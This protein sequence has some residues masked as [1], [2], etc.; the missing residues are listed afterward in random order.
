M[1]IVPFSKSPIPGAPTPGRDPPSDAFALM[2]VA[3]M[4]AEGKF[5]QQ[6]PTE[7]PNGPSSSRRIPN[8]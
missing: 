5:A 6:P 4:H 2:A 3:M 1:P 8:N 7:T